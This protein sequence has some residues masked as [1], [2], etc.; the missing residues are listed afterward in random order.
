MSLL[1]NDSDV[2]RKTI[3][4]LGNE[5]VAFLLAGFA[6][7]LVTERLRDLRGTQ[8]AQGSYT[9]SDILPSNRSQVIRQKSLLTGC[10]GGFHQECDELERT[11][12]LG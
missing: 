9:P 2:C 8:A 3:Y 4:L 1:F 10:E 6:S 12:T 11:P 7:F 5:R